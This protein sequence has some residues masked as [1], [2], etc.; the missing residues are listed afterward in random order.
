MSMKYL[1]KTEKEAIGQFLKKTLENLGHS[2]KNIM[3]HGSS[4]LRKEHGDVDVAIIIYGDRVERDPYTGEFATI[5]KSVGAYGDL[6]HVKAH[7]LHNT[8]D[9]SGVKIDYIVMPHDLIS[10]EGGY[11]VAKEKGGKDPVNTFQLFMSRLLEDNIPLYE[12]KKWINRIFWEK[13]TNLFMNKFW[14]VN[15]N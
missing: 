7:V 12:G 10:R 3:L 9:I 4:I 2:V 11:K 14:R 8:V 13:S 6:E 15:Y 5:L 1:S